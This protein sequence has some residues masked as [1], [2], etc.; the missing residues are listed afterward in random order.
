MQDWKRKHIRQRARDGKMD[1]KAAAEAL[2]GKPLDEWDDEELAWGRPRN[3]DGNFRG[4]APAWLTDEVR[5]EAVRRFADRVR[6]DLRLATTSA[7]K[8]LRKLMED[9]SEDDD[10]RFKVAAGV[11]LNAAIYLLDQ[12][13]GKATQPLDVTA[14]I[15]MAGLLGNV[16]LNPEDQPSQGF[17]EWES[18]SDRDPR[19]TADDDEEN[20]EDLA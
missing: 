13:V 20:D 19:H 4:P 11:R 12:V 1:P 15:K 5:H 2:Y 18:P 10:G 14:E 8:V 6:T 3:A 9:E 7:T 16:I 17:T